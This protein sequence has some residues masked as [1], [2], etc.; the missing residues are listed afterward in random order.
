MDIFIGWFVFSIIV[1]FIAMDRKIGFW[2]AFFLSLLLSPII[3]L[4]ITLVSKNKKEAQQNKEL[5]TAVLNS[6]TSN[7]PTKTEQLKELAGLRDSGIVDD[8]E[9]KEMKKKIMEG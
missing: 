1:G 3:G 5:Q 8:D 4:I 2:G 9:F 6:Q 7:G